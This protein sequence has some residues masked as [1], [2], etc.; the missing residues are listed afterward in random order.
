MTE[1]ETLKQMRKPMIHLGSYETYDKKKNCPELRRGGNEG[2]AEDK[3]KLL[4]GC[5]N[6]MHFQTKTEISAFHK[7]PTQSS[8]TVKIKTFNFFYCFKALVVPK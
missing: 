6:H 8:L 5:D 7:E 1:K 2:T 3:L 4:E